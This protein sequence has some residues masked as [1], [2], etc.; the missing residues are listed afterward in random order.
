M[1]TG[2]E[3]VKPCKYLSVFLSYNENKMHADEL[4]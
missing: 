1:E 3:M 4:M 2:I